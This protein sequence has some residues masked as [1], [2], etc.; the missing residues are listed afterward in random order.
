MKVSAAQSGVRATAYSQGQ[1]LYWGGGGAVRLG[2]APLGSPGC[3]E[4]GPRVVWTEGLSSCTCPVLLLLQAVL[5]AS[6]V[7]GVGAE[8]SGQSQGDATHLSGFVWCG[9][10]FPSSVQSIL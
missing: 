3:G 9:V 1:D 4:W 2:P 7:P 5:S 6:R 10:V 8:W